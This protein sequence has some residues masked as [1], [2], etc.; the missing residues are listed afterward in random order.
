MILPSLLQDGVDL[1]RSRRELAS[2]ERTEAITTMLRR[3]HDTF[4]D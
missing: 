1:F 2:H 3:S 4:L